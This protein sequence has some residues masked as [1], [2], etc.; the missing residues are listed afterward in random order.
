MEK[1]PYHTQDWKDWLKFKRAN[2]DPPL[3]D[4]PQWLP[5]IAN[6]KSGNR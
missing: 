6:H 2:S 1:W 5:W 3:P 4:K